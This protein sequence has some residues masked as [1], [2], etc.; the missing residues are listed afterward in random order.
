MRKRI[1]ILA[2]HIVVA[3]VVAALA[4]PASASST[5]AATVAMQ[6]AATTL[7]GASAI[8]G[9][10]HYRHRGYARYRFHLPY[11]SI[12][13]GYGYRPYYY[14]SRYGYYRPYRHY[15]YGYGHRYGHGYGYGPRYRFYRGEET[16]GGLDLNV[17]PRKAEV[18]VD[19]KYVGLAGQYD[20]W[21]TY[22][23]LESGNHQVILHREGYE[24]VVREIEIQ[25][26]LVADLKVRMVEGEAT[27]PETLMPPEPEIDTAVVEP[28]PAGAGAGDGPGRLR[29]SVSP[30]DAVIYLDGH[31]FGIASELAHVRA[32]ISIEAGEHKI[33][34]VRP[35]YRS[36]SRTIDVTAGGQVD[37]DVS[38]E[39][40]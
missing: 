1:S 15:R 38:L 24:T 36:A 19:G 4:I 25:A 34:V 3:L 33:E 12:G 30:D 31:F 8:A 28:G 35:G 22:L 13:Y 27:D 2:A 11:F 29:I 14:G 5:P 21:P 40:R 32:G 6:Q 39:R 20:G 26:D 18:F 7:A 9:G 37:L 17:R 16:L 10:G 23:W